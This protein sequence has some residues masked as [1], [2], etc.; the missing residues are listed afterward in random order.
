MQ[1]RGI[2]GVATIPNKVIKQESELRS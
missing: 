2:I 1:H